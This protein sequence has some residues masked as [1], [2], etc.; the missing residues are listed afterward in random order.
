MTQQEVIKDLTVLNNVLQV[1]TQ[2]RSSN[3]I[4]HVPWVSG[5]ALVSN[6]ILRLSLKKSGLKSYVEKCAENICVDI[7]FFN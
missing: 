6:L 3:N 2:V 5:K 4:N 1:G 7:F